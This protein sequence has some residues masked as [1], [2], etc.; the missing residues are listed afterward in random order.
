MTTSH[1]CAGVRFRDLSQ[2]TLAGTP[3]QRSLASLRLRD[4]RQRAQIQSA[5][6]S[7]A[8][9]VVAFAVVAFAVVAGVLLAEALAAGDLAA[10]F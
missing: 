6:G 4:C 10:G 5:G 8:F 9:A 7:P 2:R 3:N 1:T